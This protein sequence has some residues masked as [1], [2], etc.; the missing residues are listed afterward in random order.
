M[1]KIGIYGSTGR[2]GKQL[3]HSLQEREDC[4]VSYSYSRSSGGSIEDLCAN[5]DVIIDFSSPEAVMNLLPLAEN[6]KSKI[7][8]CST[9]FSEEQR[10][11][12]VL[13]SSR[14]P[15]LQAA[16]TSSSI[17]ILTELAI[18]AAKMLD[19]NYDI[20]IL[21][22]H[23]KNKKDA[24]SGTALSIGR[25]VAE[26]KDIEFVPNFHTDCDKRDNAIGFASIRAG[27][28]YGEHHVMFVNGH[29]SITLSHKSGGR[30][31]Y[32]DGAIKA[33]LWLSKSTKPGLYSMKDVF[34]TT[35]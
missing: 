30:M 8:I 17:Y 29:D 3:S 32:A 9:G 2:M 20:E 22:L 35:Y 31:T 4:V 6:Y 7:V 5:S 18:K 21:D 27:E 10:E 33:A 23:H 15:I 14:I 25:A 12:I 1:I 16:N 13:S 34:S 24:P 28:I 26:A 19:K 11:R